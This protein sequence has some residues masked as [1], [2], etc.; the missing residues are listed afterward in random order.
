[1]KYESEEEINVN[2]VLVLSKMIN[3]K[4]INFDHWLQMNQQVFHF[5][6]QTI[7]GLRLT[8]NFLKRTYEHDELAQVFV[9]NDST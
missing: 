6:F 1:M 2:E 5:I 3:L 4:D 9:Y 8:D 7:S